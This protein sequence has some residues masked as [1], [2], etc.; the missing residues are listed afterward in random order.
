MYKIHKVN[1]ATHS[2]IMRKRYIIFRL[3]TLVDCLITI[4]TLDRYDSEYE[5]DYLFRDESKI[6]NTR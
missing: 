3:L 6:Y 1:S 2:G 5:F 4:L